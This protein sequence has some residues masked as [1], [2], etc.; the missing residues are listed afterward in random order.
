MKNVTWEV[1]PGAGL[2]VGKSY[3]RG[4]V[5]TRISYYGGRNSYLGGVVGCARIGAG[6]GSGESYLQCHLAS[7]TSFSGVEYRSLG[8]VV[9]GG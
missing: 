1:G 5:G 8:C 3:R 7:R 4:R 6:L 9:F 2:G